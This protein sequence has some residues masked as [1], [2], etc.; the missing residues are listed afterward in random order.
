MTKCQVCSVHDH[1]PMWLMDRVLVVVNVCLQFFFHFS[2]LLSPHEHKKI[3][4]SLP[5]CCCGLQEY[6]QKWETGEPATPQKSNNQSNSGKCQKGKVLES[7]LLHL[8]SNSLINGHVLCEVCEDK[9]S[10]PKLR[11][12]TLTVMYVAH[13]LFQKCV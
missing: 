3:V 10:V 8:F 2:L 5:S 4:C 6:D 7:M 13:Q 12:V 11:T 9:G 1:Q